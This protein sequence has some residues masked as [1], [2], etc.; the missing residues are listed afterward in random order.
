MEKWLE[1]SIVFK[2]KFT[3]LE[4]LL[5]FYYID[6]KYYY[7]LNY[8]IIYG[9]YYIFQLVLWLNANFKTGFRKQKFGEKPGVFDLSNAKK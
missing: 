4:I 5:G 8:L 7:L 9:K 6:K 1:N 3:V 2:V